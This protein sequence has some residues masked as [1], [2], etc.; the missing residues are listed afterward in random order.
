MLMLP[1]NPRVEKDAL[2]A[3]L[4]RFHDQWEQEPTIHAFF[5]LCAAAERA[6]E[7]LTPLETGAS[8]DQET[9]LQGICLK[10]LLNSAMQART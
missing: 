2:A 5:D 1:F 6:H 7:V 8:Q 10:L 3:A 4:C 9:S